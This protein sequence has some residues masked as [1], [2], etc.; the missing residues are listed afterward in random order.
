M[1]TRRIPLSRKLFLYPSAIA[2]GM[3]FI[4][5]LLHAQPDPFE[6]APTE[7]VFEEA[8]PFEDTVPEP[9]GASGFSNP[10]SGLKAAST[11]TVK[12]SNPKAPPLSQALPED[13]T[14][15][16]YPD[17][18]ESFDYPNADIQEVVKAIS[19]LTGKNFIIDPSVSGKISIIAPSQITVAE[20]YKAFLA[21]LAI[22]QLAVV[23]AG[24]F[25]KIRR[26][27]D[28]QRD[29]IETYNGE[30]FPNYDQFITRI[31]KL[32]YINAET[33]LNQLQKTMLT[34]NSG[35]IVAYGPTNSLIISDYGSQIERVNKML[36][37]LDIPG[38]EEQLS[39]IRII[40]ARAKD[41]ADIINQIIFKG[42]SPNNRFRSGVPRFPTRQAGQGTGG[43]GSENYSLVVPDE[44]TNS[45]I[46][47][48][49]QAGIEKVRGLVR[50]LDFK[51][52][53]EDQGGVYVY[54]VKFGEAKKMAEVLNGV[55]GEAKKSR[56]SQNQRSGQPGGFPPP[57]P[58]PGEAM[59]TPQGASGAVFGGD[60][61]VSADEATNSLVITASKMDYESVMAILGKLDIPQDQ[62]FVKAYIMELNTDKTT[63]WGMNYYQFAKDT[64]GIGRLGFRGSEGISPTLNANETGAILN[65]GTGSLVKVNI[66]GMGELEVPSL[67]S[68]IRLIQ[69]NADGN[70]LSTPQ[71]MATNNQ[72]AIIEVGSQVPIGRKSN[73]TAAGGVEVSTE[74]ADV[75]IK[76]EITPFVRPQS[77]S[78]RMKIKQI[79]NQIG[80]QNAIT[81]ELAKTDLVVNKRSI[82]TNVTV[83]SGDTVVLGGL[84][85]DQ[86]TESVRKIPLLG[87]IPVLGWLFKGRNISRRKVNL[88]VFLTPQVIRSPEDGHKILDEKVSER[89]EFVKK[90]MGGRDTQGG[91]I[92]ALPRKR[93][94]ET[95]VQDE[96]P[97]PEEPAVE[98]F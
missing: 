43:S 83:D 68:F 85:Q 39:V 22:R 36:E 86:E 55:A 35:N 49:N 75:S 19:K 2:I 4:T 66:P 1:K 45:I 9:S 57:P 60:V 53:P 74:R 13:I 5:P 95:K 78:I 20:A 10:S 58:F 18:I 31:I 84:M 88:V 34:T 27:Q 3:S 8:P 65:F 63:D 59:P 87:D 61:K 96:A 6:G 71:I 40:H 7:P 26:S 46:V 97:E 51:L 48:G 33:V 42:E 41:V 21:A 12:S 56:D 72:E 73:S 37:Q 89:T 67:S 76:L 91:I 32:K 79:A 92:D 28:A 80:S 52:N 29:S 62:V 82:T 93:V 90:Y 64:K 23:P 54:Y 70:V 77:D 98:T 69:A 15:E 24:K 94:S 50:R 17:L 16:N 30:Y 14:N 47:V 38:F 44:R 11:P 81:T 25:L